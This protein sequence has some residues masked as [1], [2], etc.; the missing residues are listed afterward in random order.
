MKRRSQFALAI[1]TMAYLGVVDYAPLAARENIS[2]LSFNT[3]QGQLNLKQYVGQVIYLDF[4][5]SWC[6][7][8]RK[9]F[10]WM[11]EMQQRYTK[12]GLRIIAVNLDQDQQLAKQF[13]AEYPANFTIAFD[14]EGITAQQFKVQGMP[15]AYLIDRN[16]K[17]H[18]T[19]LG[20]KEKD[21]LAV[22]NEI[23]SLLKR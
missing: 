8:C 5:A 7:P 13:L 14:P 17:L 20:F 3:T 2:T 22:E 16:G 15:S 4:W 19:H 11:N 6:G 12:D 1:L 18:T 9:S 21:S 10:P 23:K